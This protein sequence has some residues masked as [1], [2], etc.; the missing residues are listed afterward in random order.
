MRLSFSTNA[1]TNYSIEVAIE[2]IAAIGYEGIELLADVPHAWPAG[3]IDVQK[4][5]IRRSLAERNLAIA[6]VNAFMMRAVGDLRQPY[7]HPSWLEPDEWYRRVRVEHTKRAIRLA[8]ELGAPSI[9]TEPGG[10]L[11]DGMS[12]RQGLELFARELHPVL[13]LAEECDLYLLIEPEP[14]LLIE[15]PDQYFDLLELVSSPKLG[16]NA[17]I[18]HIYCVGMEPADAVSALAG[19]VRHVHLEDIAASR[20]HQHLVPGEGAL[21]FEPVIDALRA[22]GYAGWIT[23]ELYPYAEA[24]DDAARRAFARVAPLVRSGRSNRANEQ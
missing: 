17:D 3:L 15:R 8:A 7:W 16:V 6:N 2:R 18:G 1:Y 4:E 19:H 13:E 12:Y 14:G 10:P 20:V 11:P 9:S 5:T 23:I 22:V 24:P 21:E